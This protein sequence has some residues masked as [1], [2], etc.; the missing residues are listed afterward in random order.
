MVYRLPPVLSWLPRPVARYP[1][2]VPFSSVPFSRFITR[3]PPDVSAPPVPFFRFVARHPPDVSAPPVP[4]SRFLARHS[5]DVSAPPVPFFASSRAFRPTLP[6]VRPVSRCAVR[7]SFGVSSRPFRLPFCPVSR[8]LR[9][10]LS[11]F[12]GY[13]C[14]RRTSLL[15]GGLLGKPSH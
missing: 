8:F 11:F 3:H 10:I 1:L 2:D 7:Y 9:T 5:P 15:F 14:T 4:F 6:F 13:Y 12:A